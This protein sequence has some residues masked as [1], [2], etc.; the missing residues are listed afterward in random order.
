MLLGAEY[1]AA[2]WWGAEA[3]KRAPEVMTNW[4]GAHVIDST[5]HLLQQERPEETIRVIG[6]FRAEL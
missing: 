4:M 2:T 1:D 3:I 6:T 5:G